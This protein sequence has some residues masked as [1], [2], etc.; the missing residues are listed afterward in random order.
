MP[1]AVVFVDVVDPIEGLWGEDVYLFLAGIVVQNHSEKPRSRT[2]HNGDIREAEPTIVAGESIYRSLDIWVPPFSHDDVVGDTKRRPSAHGDVVVAN[3]FGDFIKRLDAC[4]I[5]VYVHPAIMI[6]Y[7]Q[8]SCVRSLDR[9]RVGVIGRQKPWVFLAEELQYAGVGPQ[10]VG[11]VRVQPPATLDV[12]VHV[13]RA[14]IHP[15]LMYYAWEFTSD[16]RAP[17]RVRM[18]DIPGNRNWNGQ[19]DD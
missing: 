11:V 7:Q 3:L 5:H 13:P 14:V 8:A 1:V 15:D 9:M 12:R 4:Y 18:L 2:V 17:F 16:R 10:L 19:E 6:E